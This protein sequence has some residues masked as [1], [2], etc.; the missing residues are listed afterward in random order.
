[1]SA[2]NLSGKTVLVTGANRGIGAATVRELL[3]TGAA[4]VYAAA[5]KPSSLPDFDDARVVAL[6]LDLN[7]AASITAAAQTAKDVDV[8]INNAGTATFGDLL[9][10]S[11]ETVTA[12]FA[13][14]V[15][16]TL[17][18]IRA[19]APAFKARRSGTLVNVLSVVGLTAAPGLPGYSASK[20]ALQ[21]L[22]QSFR[23]T[24]K[25][26]NIDVFGVYPGPIDTDMAKDLPWDK[27]TPE[28]AAEKIVAGIQAGETYIFP[29]P[30]SEKVGYLWATDGRA[31]DSVLA[32]RAE[33]A[34]EAA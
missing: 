30:L 6:A 9:D 25:P 24:L 34:A 5:R 11:F 27:A 7:D 14:N 10:A 3:K 12:D 16:G 2:H 28:H 4:K 18:V 15:Y 17:N 13:T 1:M 31:L 32:E 20:A 8:L 26:F 23:A 22:T 19:F 29:D 33:D 21:S